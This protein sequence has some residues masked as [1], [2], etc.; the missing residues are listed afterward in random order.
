MSI[1]SFVLG[2]V[3]GVIVIQIAVSVMIMLKMKG[4]KQVESNLSRSIS[5]LETKLER[6]V[7]D[8]VGSVNQSLEELSN[9]IA[10]TEELSR[11]NMRLKRL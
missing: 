11:T 10:I 2:I 8:D 7:A 1:V 4:I 9:T 6:M 3:V 5:D